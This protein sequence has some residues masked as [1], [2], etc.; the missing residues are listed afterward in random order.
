MNN[1]FKVFKKKGIGRKPEYDLLLKQNNMEDRLDYL[2][3]SMSLFFSVCSKR[4]MKKIILK[5]EEYNRKG[6]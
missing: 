5:L 2:E 1:M 4:K 3:Y 6:N